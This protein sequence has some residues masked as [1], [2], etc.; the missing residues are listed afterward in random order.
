[1]GA[2]MKHRDTEP[3]GILKNITVLIVDDSAIN[4]NIA[5]NII[6]HH[7]GISAAACN[8]KEGVI[9]FAES[10]IGEFDIILMDIMM[11]VMN[12]YDAVKLI[13]TLDREDAVRIPIVAVTSECGDENIRK[14][15]ECG[16]D[17]YLRKPYSPELLTET[18]EKL[19]RYGR[20]RG[21]R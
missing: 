7:G 9:R 18:I 21:I 6:E 14:C 12:G 1:M 16:M 13:R 3:R 15:H 20:A 17:R 2:F 11:P 10:R 5:A 4:R 19:I 8:G